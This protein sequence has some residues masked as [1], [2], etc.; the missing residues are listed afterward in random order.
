MLVFFTCFALSAQDES[1]GNRVFPVYTVPESEFDITINEQDGMKTV[2]ITGYHG[3]A[4]ALRI[5]ERIKGIPVTVIGERAFEYTSIAFRE[6]ES[7][8]RITLP[9]GLVEIQDYAFHNNYL[10]SIIIPSSVRVIGDYAFSR[11]NL[12]NLYLKGCRTIGKMAFSYNKLVKL[13]LSEGLALIGEEAFAG[14][15]GIGVLNGNNNSITELILPHG[16]LTIGKRAFW[17]NKIERL[18]FQSGPVEIG[19][20]AFT[21]RFFEYYDKNNRKAGLYTVQDGAWRYDPR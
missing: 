2:T 9:E 4:K 19:Y 16:P 18:V 1:G 21:S 7:L 11:N 3:T 10:S 20:Q 8:A 6:T 12:E 17:D 15:R 14:E 13:V 5:P